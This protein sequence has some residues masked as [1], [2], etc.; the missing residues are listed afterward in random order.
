MWKSLNVIKKRSHTLRLRDFRWE[1]L[2]S[3]GRDLLARRSGRSVS[4][5]R[6]PCTTAGRREVEEWTVD[7]AVT[8]FLPC[9][10]TVYSP[11]HVLALVEWRHP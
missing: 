3:V 9:A 6:V 2:F 5:I 4:F 1:E 8:S 11:E 10:F 7:P